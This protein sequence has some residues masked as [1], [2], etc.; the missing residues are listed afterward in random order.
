MRRMRDRAQRRSMRRSPERRKEDRKPAPLPVSKVGSSYQRISSP[1]GKVYYRESTERD[2][3]GG[4]SCVLIAFRAAVILLM[5]P[6][7][8]RDGRTPA[9]TSSMSTSGMCSISAAAKDHLPGR[10]RHRARSHRH[11]SC[12]RPLQPPTGATRKRQWCPVEVLPIAE[13]QAQRLR[14][15]L[16]RREPRLP[17]RLKASSFSAIATTRSLAA[18]CARKR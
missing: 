18:F 4:G 7:C 13:G 14:E 10:W 5:I 2:R 16:F 11:H 15:G 3:Q 12:D 17:S 6:S 9:T 1:D 8:E